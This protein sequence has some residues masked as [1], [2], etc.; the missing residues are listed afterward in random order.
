MRVLPLV[1]LAVVLASCGPKPSPPAAGNQSADKSPS[2]EPKQVEQKPEPKKGPT[3]GSQQNTIDVEIVVRSNTKDMLTDCA[4]K[5]PRTI[6]VLAS[7]GHV[8]HCVNNTLI[9]HDEQGK[10]PALAAADVPVAESESV[11]WFCLTH[12]FIVTSI[13][14]SKQSPVAAAAPATP[15]T[16]EL[17]K[18]AASEFVTSPLPSI[19][20][21]PVQRYKVTFNIT[22]IGTV[23]PDL[24]CS[25]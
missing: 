6:Y 17:S 13:V 25:F 21:D 20:G 7:N 23:D 9:S 22:G 24:I 5:P 11:R 12:T 18:V 10:N 4:N 1:I 8:Y 19:A 2:P 16:G 14:Q 3:S 15:F